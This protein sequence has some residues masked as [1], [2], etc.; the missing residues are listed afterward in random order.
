[1]GSGHF[2][3]EAV[4]Y[5]TDKTLDFLNAF[6]WNP[7]IAQLFR[8]RETILQEMNDQEITIDP[9]RSLTLIFSNATSSSAVST[10]WI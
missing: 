2:L 4:D 6:P 9:K 3:V 1:M 10:A 8:M 7:V 5:I